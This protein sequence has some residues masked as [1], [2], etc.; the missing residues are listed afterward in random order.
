MVDDLRIIPERDEPGG[1]PQ[2]N[3]PGGAKTNQRKPQPQ[4]RSGNSSPLVGVLCFMVILVSG[5][6]AYLFLQTQTLSGQRDDLDA[7]VKVLE[8]KLSVTDESLSESGAAMQSILKGHSEDLELQMSEIRKLW[9]VAYDTNRKNIEALQ[10]AQTSQG[11]SVSSLR[12]AMTKVEASAAEIGSLKSRLD[13]AA[14]QSLAL[15]AG[16]D[17]VEG[18]LRSLSDAVT[19]MRA[20]VTSQKGLTTNHS[21]AIEAIDQ[22]RIQINQRLIQLENQLRSSP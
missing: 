2:S 1:R 8:Q 5:V 17:E 6:A 4:K 14:N 15:S 19:S 13:T 3:R 18:Q 12:G 16:F 21:E 9:G 20:E 22:Y 11:A 10:K 7:R